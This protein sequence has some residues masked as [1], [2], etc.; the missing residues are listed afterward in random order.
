MLAVGKPMYLMVPSDFNERVLHLGKVLECT[1]LDFVAEFQ[2]AIA[3]TTGSE[4]LSFAE[5]NGKFF[6]QGAYVIDVKQ[7][8]PKPVILMG[9]DGEM[10]SAEQRQAF[11]VS[12]ASVDMDARLGNE[13]HCRVLDLS[14]EGFGAIAESEF[15]LG[16]LIHVA[17]TYEGQTAFSTTAR[18]Q[19][20]RKRP[21]GK[22]RYG[23]LAPDKKSIARKAMQQLSTTIQRLQLRR[24]AGVV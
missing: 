20:A 14:A 17:V 18:V 1:Q 11:R 5:V 21:D 16:S 22:Y 4:L 12:V 9:R 24:L 3:P 23:F 13:R 2:E 10:V 15:S 7:P 8:G 19:T 6:Q